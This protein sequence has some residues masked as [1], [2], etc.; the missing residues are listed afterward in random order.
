MINLQTNDLLVEGLG[1]LTQTFPPLI[2]E[3]LRPTMSL[4]R[5]VRLACFDAFSHLVKHEL[6]VDQV[7]TAQLPELLALAAKL[8]PSS[9]QPAHL[10][11]G[12]VA[13]GKANSFVATYLMNQFVHHLSLVGLPSAA[14]EMATV[15]GG[16][17]MIAQI[18]R[19]QLNFNTRLKVVDYLNDLK[20]RPGL[21]NYLSA[22]LSVYQAK[23]SDDLI[24]LAGQVGESLGVSSAIVA[25]L[26]EDYKN[27]EAFISQVT[28]GQYPLPML[29]A[30]QAHREW[31]D[32]FLHSKHRPSKESFDRAYQLTKESFT[33]ASQ[34]V[35][36]QLKQVELDIKLFPSEE[37]RRELQEV[38]DEL[39]KR[40]NMFV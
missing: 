33:A 22:E 4:T 20:V 29:F 6:T 32:H 14:I 2:K 5:Q 12:V 18:Q 38:I 11:P 25:E 10:N 8:N 27:P 39:T 36:D 15:T 30:M 40:A 13:N 34:I 37:C 7:T 3:M 19:L 35:V 16:D 23:A 9:F 24:N 1:S 26:E 31:F 28:A 21:L 17:F